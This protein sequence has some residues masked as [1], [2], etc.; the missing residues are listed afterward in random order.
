MTF[1]RKIQRYG[2]FYDKFNKFTEKKVFFVKYADFL[3]I[4]A[5]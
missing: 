1:Y 5:A 3:R 4:F 2:I